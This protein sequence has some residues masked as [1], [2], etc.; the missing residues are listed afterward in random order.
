MANTPY[1][2]TLPT[3]NGTPYQPGKPQAAPQSPHAVLA[4]HYGQQYANAAPPLPATT[5]Q[6]S[7][8]PTTS[9]AVAPVVKNEP[10]SM[11]PQESGYQ[12]LIDWWTNHF[13]GMDE[14]QKQAELA[15]IAS[16]ASPLSA[17][18]RE[19]MQNLN[20][21]IP[22]EWAYVPQP[23]KQLPH[24]QLY[25]K[26]TLDAF[27]PSSLEQEQLYNGLPPEQRAA[28]AN[29]SQG[30]VENWTRVYNSERFTQAE[31]DKYF[32]ELQDTQA[33]RENRLSAYNRQ[34]DA[35]N[36][37]EM[38]YQNALK[39]QAEAAQARTPKN[40]MPYFPS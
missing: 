26:A 34:V 19:F 12:N 6:T 29:W 15:A 1:L 11:N 14:A 7:L 17:Q 33:E 25:G 10:P 28:M 38:A 24:G 35:Y 31:K 40:V 36:A 22:K 5:Q 13:G 30:M 27:K 8:R 4:A 18:A 3:L 16:G 2:P 20:I 23:L 9:G 21:P 39:A 32:K 37:N